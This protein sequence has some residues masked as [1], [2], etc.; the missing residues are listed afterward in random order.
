MHALDPPH[1][2]TPV[3]DP[4][5]CPRCQLRHTRRLDWLCPRCG[6]PVET[7]V[8]AP[9]TVPAPRVEPQQFPLGSRIAGAILLLASGALARDLVMLP[10]G[11]HR[12]RLLAA[13]AVLAGLGLALLLKVTLARWTAVALA[14]LAAVVLTEGLFRDLWPG[15]VRDPLPGL[16]RQLLRDLIHDHHPRQILSSLGFDAGCLLLV[17][18]RPRAIRIA[19]AVLL[20]TPLLLLEVLAALGGR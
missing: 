10:A 7:E 20:A 14:V 2:V 9:G 4:A 18:G 8:P 19:N 12:L 3:P 6:S 5:Y 11:A 1:V 16:V 15:L 13:G 17:V